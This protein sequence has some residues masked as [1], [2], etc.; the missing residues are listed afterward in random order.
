LKISALITVETSVPTGSDSA[1]LLTYLIPYK[2]VTF[3]NVADHSTLKEVLSRSKTS[4]IT[5]STSANSLV[6]YQ[7]KLNKVRHFIIMLASRCRLLRNY[8]FWIRLR[9]RVFEEFRSGFDVWK[10]SEF[11]FGSNQRF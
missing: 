2:M 1:K 3:L 4:T 6:P 11:G 10:S 9:I 7:P 8:L 5:T